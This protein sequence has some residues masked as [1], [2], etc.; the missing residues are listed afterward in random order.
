[1]Y[2]MNMYRLYIMNMYEYVYIM[3]MYMCIY[4]YISM[5]IIKKL[6]PF[7]DPEADFLK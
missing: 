5:Y 6:Q 1:M 7:A 4:I 3:N 2:N